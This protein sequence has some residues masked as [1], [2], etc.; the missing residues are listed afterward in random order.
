MIGYV[1]VALA[2]LALIA[3]VAWPLIRPSLHEGSPPA[4]DDERAR[5]QEDVERSLAAIREI[6]FD[7]RAGNLSDAD[8][9]ALDGAERARTAEL[10]RRLDRLDSA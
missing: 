9:A 8:Y 5:I 7:H 1:L 3:V 10:L 2:A 6:E 4:P